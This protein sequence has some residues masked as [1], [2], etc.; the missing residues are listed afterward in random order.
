MTV[1]LLIKMGVPE[2]HSHDCSKGTSVYTH[3]HTH[4]QDAQNQ[5][6][7]IKARFWVSSLNDVPGKVLQAHILNLMHLFLQ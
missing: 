2:E 6:L 1:L 5:N 7:W 4:T 3:T